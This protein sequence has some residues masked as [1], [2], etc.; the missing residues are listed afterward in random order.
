MVLPEGICFLLIFFVKVKILLT[1]AVLD[2][3]ALTQL[4]FFFLEMVIFNQFFYLLNVLAFRGS[5]MTLTV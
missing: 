2:F 1:L 5:E 4:G 3:L